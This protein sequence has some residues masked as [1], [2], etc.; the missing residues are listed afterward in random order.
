MGRPR[1][2]MIISR[3][4]GEKTSARRYFVWIETNTALSLWV[5]NARWFESAVAL[6]CRRLR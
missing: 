2:P 1:Q 4:C 6:T 3:Y 5:L